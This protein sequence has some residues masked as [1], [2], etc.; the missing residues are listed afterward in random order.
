VLL[1]LQVFPE[2]YQQG[3]VPDFVH[4]AKDKWD[5]PRGAFNERY[6]ELLPI[7]E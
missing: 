7:V 1:I 6:Y 4:R 3:E 5:G 2:I